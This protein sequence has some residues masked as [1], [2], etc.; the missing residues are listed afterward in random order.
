[1]V[2]SYLS[3]IDNGVLAR[4][5]ELA[6]RRLEACTLCPRNCKVNRRAGK[7]GVCRTG[8]RARVA[9]Y[10]P[11]HGEE[12]PLSGSHGSGT[13]FFSRCNLRCV[14]CQN[15]AISRGDLGSEVEPEELAAI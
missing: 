7:L 1:M 14:Y 15:A 12:R 2:P 6:Y 3:L 10:G 9:S 4:R 5:V 8:E 13:V 11:H